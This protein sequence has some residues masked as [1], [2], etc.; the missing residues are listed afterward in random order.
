M[1]HYLLGFIVDNIGA[2]IVKESARSIREASQ[3]IHKDSAPGVVTDD[4]AGY[5]GVGDQI[6]LQPLDGVAVQL[7]GNIREV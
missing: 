7:Y 4:Q 5:V 3:H 2:D 6:A 1:A